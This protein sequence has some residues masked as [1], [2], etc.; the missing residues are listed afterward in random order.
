[1]GVLIWVV[2]V[3]VGVLAREADETCCREVLP[4]ALEYLKAEGELERLDTGLPWL[5]V[6]FT[7][8]AN[9]GRREDADAGDVG[10]IGEPASRLAAPKSG[11]IKANF[12]PAKSLW[13]REW[14]LGTLEA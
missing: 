10:D 5:G 6:S 11:R 8:L 9:L 4:L 3:L 2:E 13:A 14:L 12:D 7:L 1:V